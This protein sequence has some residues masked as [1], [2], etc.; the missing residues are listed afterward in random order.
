MKRCLAFVI[1]RKM[2]NEH[3]GFAVMAPITS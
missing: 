2:F 3:T 1:S